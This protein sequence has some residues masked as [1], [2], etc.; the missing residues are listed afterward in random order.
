MIILLIK[1]KYNTQQTLKKEEFHNLGNS[2][3]TERAAAKSAADCAKHRRAS[4]P[5]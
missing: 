3:V 5:F 1:F 4:V 2:R